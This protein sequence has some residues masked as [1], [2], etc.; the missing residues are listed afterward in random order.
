MRIHRFL[1][2]LFALIVLLTSCNNPF[3]PEL[4][5][6]SGIDDEQLN[7]TPEKLLRNLER[8][9][10]EKNIDLYLSL[11]HPDFRFELIASEVS[12]I[13]VD[14]NGDQINDSW[15]GYEQEREF[16]TRMF[17]EGSSDGVYPPPDDISLRLQIPPQ[18]K[19][20][21]DSTVGHEDWI[22]ITCNFD[23][24]LSYVS[25]NSSFNANGKAS[26]YLRPVNNRWYIA[27]WRDE[28]FI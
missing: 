14:L 8:A 28:S 17:I 4:K 18:D 3:R 2:L 16:T 5:D 19:W 1:P 23:L 15:W 21:K 11:L 9:Y 20:E 22:I 7:S 10:Q 24:I 27:I 12:Q 6:V 26:F 25:T 13:G